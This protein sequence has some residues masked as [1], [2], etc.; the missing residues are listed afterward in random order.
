MIV[1]SLWWSGERRR[2]YGTLPNPTEGTFDLGY[3]DLATGRIHPASSGP[4]SRDRGPAERYLML[5][6]DRHPFDQQ[7]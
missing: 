6:R 1:G 5:Q 7:P 2:L 4:P 3:A